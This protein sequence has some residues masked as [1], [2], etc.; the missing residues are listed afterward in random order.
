VTPAASDRRR[1]LLAT[2]LLA[3][4]GTQAQARLRD[5]RVGLVPYLSTRAMLGL[6]QPLRQH[7]EA[8]LRGPVTLFTA[9][10]FRALAENARSG[11]YA[12]ALLPGHLVRVAVEDWG[13]TLVVR[14]D[15]V[16]EVQLIARKGSEPALPDGLRGRRIAAI[17]PLSMT[18]MSLRLWLERRGLT[19]GRDVA[20]DYLRSAGSAAIAVQRGDAVAM[21]GA[22]GQ[23]R[24]LGIGEVSDLIKVATIEL[25][26]TP[27]FVAHG[28]VPPDEIAAWQ[29]ALLDFV[30]PAGLEGGLSRQRFVPGNLRDFDTVMAY[31][32]EARRLLA[33]PRPAVRPPE[34]NRS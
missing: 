18:S 33:Q 24:D 20:I 4:G 2:A 12:L 29:R 26:P 9:A 28:S 10:D 1:L 11:E 23:L 6:Y 7:L 13:H 19:I 32:A 22:V 14:N 27:A 25:I 16:S 31:S 30:P 3:A 21:V 8:A 15:L 17:D 34:P 5:L